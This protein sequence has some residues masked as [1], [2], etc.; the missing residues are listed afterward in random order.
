MD[1]S[2]DR[3]HKNDPKPQ[4]DAGIKDEVDGIKAEDE[5]DVDVKDEMAVKEEDGGGNF[6]VAALGENGDREDDVLPDSLK[7]EV[8]DGV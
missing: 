4:P 6:E 8:E 7:E 2:K 5:L 1:H 3:F